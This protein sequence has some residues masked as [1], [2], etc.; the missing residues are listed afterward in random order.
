MGLMKKMAEDISVS[1]GLDGEINADVICVAERVLEAHRINEP[2]QKAMET[3]RIA[4][5]MRQLQDEMFEDGEIAMRVCAW[6]KAEG[7]NGFMGYTRGS[8]ITHGICE[9]HADE[10]RGL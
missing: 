1:L 10:I 3:A 9:Y 5:L 6:C 4:K 7:K 8:G 2:F